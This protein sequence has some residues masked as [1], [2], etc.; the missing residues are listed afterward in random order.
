MQ[1]MKDQTGLTTLTILH[2]DGEDFQKKFQSVEFVYVRDSSFKSLY[3]QRFLVTFQ[4]AVMTST[5]TIVDPLSHCTTDAKIYRV[6][7]I[8][9]RFFIRLLTSSL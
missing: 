9:Y 5:A 8:R 3:I 7:S 1:A 2:V 6:H 4:S